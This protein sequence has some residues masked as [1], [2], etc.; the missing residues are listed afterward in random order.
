M[1]AMSEEF[2]RHLRVAFP[3]PTDTSVIRAVSEGVVL[4]DDVRRNTTWLSNLIGDDLTGQLRRAAAMWR[5]HMYCKSGDLPFKADEIPNSTGSSHLLRIKS[6]NFEAHVVRTESAGAF[7]KD[8]PIRQDKRLSNYGDLFDEPKLEPAWT[9]IGRV[10]PYAWLAFN[11][12]PIGSATHICWCMPDRVENRW[13]AHINI[14]RRAI[15]AGAS[16][17]PT[18]QLPKPDPTESM[19]FKKHIEERIDTKKKTK[20]DGTG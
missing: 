5:L 15:A 18:Q 17:E 14:L 8:A 6:D 7:P 9:L 20:G 1:V 4:A 2:E 12:T 11:A 19:K 10:S 16:P 3:E 13:L